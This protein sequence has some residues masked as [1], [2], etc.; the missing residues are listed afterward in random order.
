VLKSAFKEYEFTRQMDF[1]KQFL[2]VPV[3]YD[4]IFSETRQ[5]AKDDFAAFKTAVLGQFDA[6]E[7]AYRDAVG[8][9][10]D[11]YA[12]MIGSGSD[13]F[14]WTHILDVILYRFSATIRMGIDV[15]VA[16]QILA[17]TSNQPHLTWSVIAHSLGTSVA[18]NT[19]N[20]LH[21]TG[22]PGIP[23]LSPLASRCNT[24]AMV[25]NVSRVLQRD[26]AKVYETDVRPGSAAAGRLC[27]YYLNARHKLD[28]LTVPKSFEPGL[29]PDA[30][31]FSTERYQHIRP[32]HIHFESDQLSRVHDLDHYLENPRVH[33]PL[34]R[35]ILGRGIV[36]DE[37]YR[38]AKARFD[39]EIVSGTLDDARSRLESR[40]PALSGNW[41]NLLASIKRLLP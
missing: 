18:H 10:L 16:K 32:S 22:F 41:R 27:S 15:S 17:T 14:I 5:R 20:K 38:S 31:S 3:V 33:V 11:K 1:D 40:L 2:A 12:N 34:F 8:N 39:S 9:E 29:W 13:D 35:S 21:N 26:T 19:L 24:L 30:A 28:L 36:G 6:A 23:P 7:K 37:E 4:D 25:S